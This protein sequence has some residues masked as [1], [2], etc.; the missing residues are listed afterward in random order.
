MQIN[1]K[2]LSARLSRAVSVRSSLQK[3]SIHG[4]KGM[5]EIFCT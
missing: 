4:E 5:L 1:K 2:A 3:V